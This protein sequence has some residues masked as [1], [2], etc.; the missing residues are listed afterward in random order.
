MPNYSSVTG[1]K[2]ISSYCLSELLVSYGL[3]TSL[4]PL[5]VEISSISRSMRAE[6][7]DDNTTLPIVK[8]SREFHARAQNFS[9]IDL[10][11]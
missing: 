2:C 10:I 4:F 11:Y 7:M 6:L 9:S 5:S 3:S 8:M 1:T